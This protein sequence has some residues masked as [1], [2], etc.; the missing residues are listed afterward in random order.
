MTTIHDIMTLGPIVPV[1]TIP[2]VEAAVPMARALLAKNIRSIEVTLRTESALDAIQAIA[3]DVPEITV[4]AGTIT[5]VAKFD[6][7][8]KAGAQFIVSPGVTAK[9]LTHAKKQHTPYL[10]GVQSV[11]E[12][13]LALEHG[14]THLK[15]FPAALAGGTA[16]LLNFQALFPDVVFC[17]TGGIS[18]ATKDDYL[19]LGNVLCVGGSWVIPKG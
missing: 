11:S 14:F 2:S 5:S 6:A 1:A 4:G 16:M 10:P 12:I 13:M 19:R 9:L 7:A 8:V 3:R 17:P 18:E 15:F